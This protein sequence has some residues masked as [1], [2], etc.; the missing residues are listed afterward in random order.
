MTFIELARTRQS[1]RKYLNRPVE[2]EKIDL[3]IEAAR[4]APS[5]CN[6][7]PWKFIVIKGAKRVELIK[8][9]REGIE[10][11]KARGEDLGSTENDGTRLCRDRGAGCGA[12]RAAYCPL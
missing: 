10:K 11:T 7:Q 4:I 9:M 8:I 2:K 1:V 3:C 12:G 5:A 6:A